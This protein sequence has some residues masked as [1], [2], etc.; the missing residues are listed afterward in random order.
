LGQKNRKKGETGARM[1]PKPAKPKAKRKS[2]VAMWRGGMGTAFSRKAFRTAKGKKRSGRRDQ[3][4]LLQAVTELYNM[5]C[6]R[7]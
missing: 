1:Q 4:R 7:A 3:A 5:A 6:T 2:G